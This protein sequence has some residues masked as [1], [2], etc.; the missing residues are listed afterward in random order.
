MGRYHYNTKQEADGLNSISVAFLKKHRYFEEG[1]H[2]GSITWTRSSFWGESKSSIGVTTTIQ[3]DTGSLQ[4]NY[5]IT[6][7][8]DDKESFNY[9]VGLVTTPCHFG[10]NRWWFVC[11]LVKSGVPCRKRVGKLYRAGDHFGCRH[12]Y[13]LTYESKNQNR[14]YKHKA[15]FDVLTMSDQIE[16]LEAEI[17]RPY[18][19]GKPTRKYKK[20]L[21]LYYQQDHNY[22]QFRELQRKK[23]V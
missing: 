13:E 2:S 3:K 16:K 18:Y 9:S 21:K 22:D 15:M 11:P 12:C 5:T 10:G 1:W 8:N 14:R 20:L 6:R 23:L 7:E 17:Q 19:N 4:L